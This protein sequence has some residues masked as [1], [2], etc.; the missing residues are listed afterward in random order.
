MCFWIFSCSYEVCHCIAAVPPL[1]G[2]VIF[3][4]E[5]H[6]DQFEHPELRR[7]ARALP[8]VLVQ[9]RAATTVNTY[10]C[11]YKSWASRNDAAFLPA[12]PV[13]FKL[14]I[15]YLI[16]QTW[17]VS[18]VNS[19]VYGVSWV[20]KKSGYQDPSEYLV[21]KQVADAARRILAKQLS[22]RNHSLLIW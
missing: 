11:A 3:P 12:D 18:S 2:E 6:G 15:M 20:H 5:F 13:V 14:Y 22:V 21:V 10:L 4:A 7:V 16:Q 8:A 9:D 17:L 19:A 1:V